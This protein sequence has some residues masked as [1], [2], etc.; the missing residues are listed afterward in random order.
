MVHAQP[1]CVRFYGEGGCEGW[2]FVIGLVNGWGSKA[3][4]WM[5]CGDGKFGMVVSFQGKML[6]LVDN[7]LDGLL[8]AALL[9]TSGKQ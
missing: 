7:G 5:I 2:V 9:V 3:Q 1:L 6:L 4:L 8:G